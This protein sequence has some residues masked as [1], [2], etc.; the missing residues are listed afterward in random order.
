VLRDGS[1][2]SFVSEVQHGH[3]LGIAGVVSHPGNYI[4]DREAGLA[5]NAENCTP[6]LERARGEVTAPVA[7]A[8][9]PR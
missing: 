7:G 4:D 5:W 2:T 1:I 9:R 8:S 3:Q 6:V